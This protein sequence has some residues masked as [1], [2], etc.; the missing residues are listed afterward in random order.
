[1]C[2]TCSNEEAVHAGE[3]DVGLVGGVPVL[4]QSQ[5]TRFEGHSFKLSCIGIAS[6]QRS[7]LQTLSHHTVVPRK[8]LEI[9]T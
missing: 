9:R 7:M 8:I 6:A 1:M 2:L 3:G 4:L 5:P